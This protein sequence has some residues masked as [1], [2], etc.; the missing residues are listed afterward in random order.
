MSKL[1]YLIRHSYAE[2]GTGKADFERSLTTEGLN[3]VRALGR[4]LIKSSFNPSL[5]LCSSARRTRET[6]QNLIEEIEMSEKN[7]EFK[8]V[9]YNASVRELLVE[10]NG[11]QSGVKEV[12]IIGHNPTITYFA[13]YLTGETIGNM[14]PSSMATIAFDGIGWSEVSQNSG[15]LLS[16]FHPRHLNV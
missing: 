2:G 7:V 16:Y 8:D 11:L 13:E 14:D 12:G 6:A 15:N 4:H 9:I 1:L 5:I 10:V 3:T